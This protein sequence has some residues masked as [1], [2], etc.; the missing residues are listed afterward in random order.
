MIVDCTCNLIDQRGVAW[1][2]RLRSRAGVGALEERRPGAGVAV[3]LESQDAQVGGVVH[4]HL[5][6]EVPGD[7]PR[8]ELAC[9]LSDVPP[10]LAVVI[11]GEVVLH[12]PPLHQLH[13]SP[14]HLAAPQL[15]A[16]GHQQP[17]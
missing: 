10:L 2:I 15:H 3:V 13:R 8:L 1:A 12:Q 4:E 6:D 14:C 11:L 16:H 7:G 17:Q 9:L 5:G